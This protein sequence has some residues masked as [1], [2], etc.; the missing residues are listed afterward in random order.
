MNEF[1][2]FKRY[3][4]FKL[5][6]DTCKRASTCRLCMKSINK[7]SD[8]VVLEYRPNGSSSC[9]TPRHGGKIFVDKTFLHPEC[10]KTWSGASEDMSGYAWRC[11][12]CDVEINGSHHFCFIGTRSTYGRLCNTCSVSSHW[13]RCTWCGA[14]YP[15][16]M[17]SP[18]QDERMDSA[19]DFCAESER[20]KTVK[21]VKRYKRRQRELEQKFESLRDAISQNGVWGQKVELPPE[22]MEPAPWEKR[23]S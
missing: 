11:H 22:L 18:M 12:D 2:P 14:F 17:T 10:L 4:G 21:A 23:P 16:Y 13:R 8:R 19:C 9:W 7:G 1:I 15:R 3:R 20:L 5:Y 6:T